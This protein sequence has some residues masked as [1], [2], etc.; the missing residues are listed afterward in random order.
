M[1]EFVGVRHTLALMCF[2]GYISTFTM[3]VSLSVAIVAMTNSTKVNQTKEYNSDT[4]PY[5]EDYF[6]EEEKEVISNGR[7]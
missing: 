6:S 5:P 1:T 7:I 4:C 3:R 2:L